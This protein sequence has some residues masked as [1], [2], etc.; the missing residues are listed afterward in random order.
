M[1]E[2]LINIVKLIALFTIYK[3]RQINA[4]YMHSSLI[5]PKILLNIFH[6]VHA[7]SRIF[8]DHPTISA[9]FFNVKKH[10]VSIS[11]FIIC[12]LFFFFYTIFMC[13]QYSKN[14]FFILFIKLV[15]KQFQKSYLSQYL[16][17]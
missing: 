13:A 4:S 8:L 3:T 11:Y 17:E 14:Y 10:T 1:I 2:E 6:L 5:N 7:I 15:L 12:L 16:N 9:I